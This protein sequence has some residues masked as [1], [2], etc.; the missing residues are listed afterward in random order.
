MA[1]DPWDYC[2]AK[3]EEDIEGEEEVVENTDKSHCIVSI[4]LLEYRK[5]INS[6][7]NEGRQCGLKVL[8]VE[9][10]NPE[11]I[12][13]I[14]TE[15]EGVELAAKGS[16]TIPVIFTWCGRYADAGQGSSVYPHP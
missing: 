1:S 14:V 9:G 7:Q 13:S 4:V 2:R 8:E 16:R 3:S 15:W 6:L 11:L 10:Q 5:I 12:F